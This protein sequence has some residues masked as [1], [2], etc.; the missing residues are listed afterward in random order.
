[1]DACG[2]VPGRGDPPLLWAAPSL[3]VAPG[4]SQQENPTEW[5]P[6]SSPSASWLRCH[7]G[8]RL[9]PSLPRH[10]GPWNCKA[11]PRQSHL[12]SAAF[13]MKQVGRGLDARPDP[14][15]SQRRALSATFLLF[16]VFL[17]L[18]FPGCAPPTDVKML[19]SWRA[20]RLLCGNCSVW[21]PRRRPGCDESN[22]FYP[23]N[24][25]LNRM[26]SWLILC[27]LHTSWSHQR[28][29]NRN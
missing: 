6:A 1:M 28:G 2:W 4:P 16:V 18:C 12:P 21:S 29:G 27:Q 15:F 23:F 20:S 24:L 25:E 9:V 11:Q 3:G 8:S 19:S 7:V 10:S 26:Q 17:E 22:M 14:P 5:A 13:E